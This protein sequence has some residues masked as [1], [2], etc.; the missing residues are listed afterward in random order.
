[1]PT[2]KTT[3]RALPTTKG[4]AYEWCRIDIEMAVELATLIQERRVFRE[5]LIYDGLHGFASPGNLGGGET[6]CRA[7]EAAFLTAPAITSKLKDVVK[8]LD[9]LLGRS[10]D[11]QTINAA[12]LRKGSPSRLAPI[13][14]ALVGIRRWGKRYKA[15]MVLICRPLKERDASHGSFDIEPLLECQD[16]PNIKKQLDALKA[17]YDSLWK[18]YV[19][20]H[21]AFHNERFEREHGDL[22]TKISKFAAEHTGLTWVNAISFA[23]LLGEPLDNP[24]F[25]AFAE[26][27][28]TISSVFER[29]KLAFLPVIQQNAVSD[30]PQVKELFDRPDFRTQIE[31]ELREIPLL[32]NSD[33][34]VERAKNALSTLAP[35]KPQQELS[36]AALGTEGFWTETIV[37][38]IKQVKEHGAQNERNVFL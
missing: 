12:E 18:V 34:F 25:L 29:L 30:F 16:P 1:M 2:R 20:I 11:N 4:K 21:P 5:A 22:E 36:L 32:D 23:E 35:K 7:L 3:D 33:I 26:S 27:D 14:K 15:P 28:A 9:G 13:T 17:S 31:R 6:S 10:F 37:K 8:E 19:F 38:V 24:T